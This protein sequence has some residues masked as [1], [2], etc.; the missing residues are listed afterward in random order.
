[1]TERIHGRVGPHRESH[2]PRLLASK[3]VSDGLVPVQGYL[4]WDG[5]TGVGEDWGMDGNDVWG[6]CGSAATDHYNIA[7][8]QSYAQY[9]QLGM[10]KY[11]GTLGTYWAYGLAQGEVGQPP[12]TPDQ[13]DQGVDNATW[14]AFLYKQGIIDGYAEVTDDVYDWFAQTFRGAILG[15][16]ID[17]AKAQQEFSIWPKVPW[18]AMPKQD[19]HDTLGIITHSDGS[20][21]LITWGAVQPYTLG[22][23]QTNWTDMWVIFDHDDPNVNWS[24]LQQALDEVHGVVTLLPRENEREGFFERVETYIEKEFAR[25][26]A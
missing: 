8:T 7:K 9:G 26:S 25:L 13:P 6:D 4:E 18:T 16:A 14:L 22:F 12:H 1:M 10:P 19:G 17:G 3:F 5:T 2:E 11:A 23:R 24:E 15:L 20:G 21:S